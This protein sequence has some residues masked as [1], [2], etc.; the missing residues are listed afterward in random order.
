MSF[1]VQPEALRRVGNDMRTL[2]DS[3]ARA[4]SFGD[5]YLRVEGTRGTQLV[6]IGEG[7]NGFR[8]LMVKDYSPGGHAWAAYHGF[9]GAM[10]SL[11]HD[12]QTTDGAQAA[13]YDRLMDEV[14]LNHVEA[15]RP[16]RHQPSAWPTTPRSS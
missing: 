3:V 9:G 14:D 2:A 5:T 10:H 6:E 8:G 12:Y 15:P 13:R 1:T 11:A 4:G 16:C 7:I